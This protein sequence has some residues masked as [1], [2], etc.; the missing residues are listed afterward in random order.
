M[1]CSWC[2]RETAAVTELGEMGRPPRPRCAHSDC[3]A[4][5]PTEAP[6]VRPPVAL[7]VASADASKNEPARQ[8]TNGSP[9]SFA[10]IVAHSEARLAEVRTRIVELRALEAEEK[11]LVLILAAAGRAPS[12]NK[13]S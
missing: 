9:P 10:Q 12:E 13:P 6:V 5:L 7:A 4:M 11:Q 3:K 8:A 1:I 2:D